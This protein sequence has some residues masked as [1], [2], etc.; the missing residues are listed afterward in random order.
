MYIR[1]YRNLGLGSGKVGGSKFLHS[2]NEE[3]VCCYLNKQHL[4]Y[5]LPLPLKVPNA[6][7]MLPFQI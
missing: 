2:E 7:H 3:L 6:L 4:V 5:A 1:D